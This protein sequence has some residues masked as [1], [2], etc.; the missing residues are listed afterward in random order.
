[1]ASDEKPSTGGDTLPASS[2][3]APPDGPLI[4]T[5]HCG[6]VQVS[7]PSKPSKL[8]ECQCTVC[9]KYGAIWGY[10]LNRDVTVTTAPGNTVVQYIRSDPESDGDLSFN[11]CGHC[12]CL[13]HWRGTEEYIGPEYRIGVNCRMLPPSAIEGVERRVNPGP[14]RIPS[15]ARAPGE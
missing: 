11:R 3:S 7:I 10:F 5:C 1:M 8:N 13:T 4:A 15:E 6:R 12:G 14:T 9:Y 2:S